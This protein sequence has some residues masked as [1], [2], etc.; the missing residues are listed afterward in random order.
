MSPVLLFNI[1]VVVFMIWTGTGKLD[2][3]LAIAEIAPEVVIEELAAIID[4]EAQNREGQM[5]F[6]ICNSL[7]DVGV[8]FVPDGACFRPLAENISQG[9]APDEVA[10]N[11]IAAVGDRVS[12]DEARANDI[13][14]GGADGNLQFETMPWAGAG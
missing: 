5:G 14:M 1:G 9:N 11:G 2:G 10:F 7:G 6:D 4:M 13:V 3:G 12:L 8:A